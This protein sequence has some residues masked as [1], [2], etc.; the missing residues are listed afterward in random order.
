MTGLQALG[1][2]NDVEGGLIAPRGVNEVV[3]GMAMLRRLVKLPGS[4][5]LSSLPARCWFSSDGVDR[6]SVVDELWYERN[7]KRASRG[8]PKQLAPHS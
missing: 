4:V 8:N 1:R 2:S 5:V 3:A 6:S 7:V